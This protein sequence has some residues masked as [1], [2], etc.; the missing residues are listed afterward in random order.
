MIRRPETL[1]GE[2]KLVAPTLPPPT[3]DLFGAANGREVATERVHVGGV[4]ERDAKVA[5]VIEDRA[6]ARFV[7]LQSKGHRAQTN[8][9]DVEPGA[10]QASVLHGLEV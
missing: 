2:H 9:G 10:A 1:R 8:A 3:E 6:R 4:D 7:D 5:R